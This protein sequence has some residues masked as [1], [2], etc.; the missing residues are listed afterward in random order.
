M[1]TASKLHST[2]PN[3]G[4]C[5]AAWRLQTCHCPSDLWKVQAGLL[6]TVCRG[7]GC[8]GC[9][10]AVSSFLLQCYEEVGMRAEVRWKG[11]PVPL[12]HRSLLPGGN[13]ENL[14]CSLRRQASMFSAACIVLF[15][16][17]KTPP[18]S[19]FNFC[20][21]YIQKYFDI[22]VKN[23][24]LSAVLCVEASWMLFGAPVLGVPIHTPGSL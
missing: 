1:S 17:L 12:L 14:F 8:S 23:I 7:S 24:K 4:P 15:Q 13:L 10:G 19:L 3:H 18:K 20:V 2:D 11:V 9:G 16:I 22:F 21:G 5:T 6:H